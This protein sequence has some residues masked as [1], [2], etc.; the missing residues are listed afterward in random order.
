MA[1]SLSEDPSKRRVQVFKNVYQHLEHWKA[2]MEDRGMDPVITDPDSSEDIYIGDLLVGLDSLPPRQRQAFELICLRHYTEGAARDEAMPDSKSST[3][4]QQ[5]AHSGLLRMI[6]AY[7]LKQI[8]KWPPLEE[9]KPKKAPTRKKEPIIMAALHPLIRTGLE[10]TREE[11]VAQLK[12]LQDALA[13]V[14]QL[15]GKTK[16][17]PEVKAPAPTPTPTPEGKPKLSDMAKEA[18]ASALAATG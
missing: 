8:G 12:E 10:T 16:A 5:A 3:P 11:I 13:Q 4:V 2:L 15:L 9:P 18:T 1:W 17:A 14:D 7:D 6:T